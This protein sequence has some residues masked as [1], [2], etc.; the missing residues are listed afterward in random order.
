MQYYEHFVLLSCKYC[1]KMS[2]TLLQHSVVLY[3]SNLLFPFCCLCVTGFDGHP[4]SV[5]CNSQFVFWDNV[6]SSG[7]QVVC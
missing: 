7:V 3:I 1:I 2:D 6:P 4:S 5:Y